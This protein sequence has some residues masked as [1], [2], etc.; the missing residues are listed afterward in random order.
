MSYSTPDTTARGERKARLL[1]GALAVTALVAAVVALWQTQSTPLAGRTY[2]WGAWP[3]R[4]EPFRRGD[5]HRTSDESAP[6]PERPSGHCLL[7][8]RGG[9]GAGAYEQE[10]EVRLGTGPL[11]AGPRRGWLSGLLVGGDTA[12]PGRLPGFTAAGSGTLVLPESC[13]VVGRPSVVTLTSS[14][15]LAGG[16]RGRSGFSAAT[17]PGDGRVAR[18]GRRP[19]RQGRPLH[20]HPAAER[21][22]RRRR[23]AS[24]RPTPPRR[25]PYE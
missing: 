2:C 25:T 23:P 13:D 16:E 18:P 17:P 9:R 4:A 5:H 7:R 20:A 3:E 19:R 12:L 8:W 1:T 6:T 11:D 21:A 24:A 10:V 15:T 14:F 22:P